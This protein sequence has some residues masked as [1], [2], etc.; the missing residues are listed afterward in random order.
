MFFSII[1][2]SSLKKTFEKVLYEYCIKRSRRLYYCTDGKY[3]TF[4]D[5]VI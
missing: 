1:F 2:Q 4:I 5:Y 3:K